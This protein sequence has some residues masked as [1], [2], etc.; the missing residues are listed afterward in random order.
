[1]NPE[2]KEPRKEGRPSTSS[3]GAP[4][5]MTTQDLMA[6]NREIVIVHRGEKYRLKI[7]R[8][9]KLILMK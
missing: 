6:G 1:M 5:T 2:P 3:A 4:R 8:S 7:T 9:D